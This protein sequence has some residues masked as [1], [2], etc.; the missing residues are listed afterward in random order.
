MNGPKLPK[1]VRE[2]GEAADAALKALQDGNE[3]ET[4]SKPKGENT[5]LDENG[6]PIQAAP[7][8][9]GTPP[10]K[11]D[12]KSKDGMDWKTEHGKL[13]QKYNVLK[14]KYDSEVPALHGEVREVKESLR[15]L[16][17]RLDQGETAPPADPGE[18][19]KTAFEV[20]AETVELF[21]ENLIKFI[22]QRAK[23]YSDS[24]VKPLGERMDT[25]THDAESDRRENFFTKLE[26]AHSDWEQINE[27]EQFKKF[28]A[29]IVPELGVERQVIINNAINSG[30][31]EP[32]ILQITAFK[33]RFS[34]QGEQ[35]N[36][37]HQETPSGE[38]T[39][40][41]DPGT[42]TDVE[43]IK[44][45]DIQAFYKDAA[46]GKYRGRDEEFIRLER[47]IQKASE[48]GKIVMDLSGGKQPVFTNQ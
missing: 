14:G 43:S 42:N 13:L 9:P 16:Q 20:P 6:N 34:N 26:E 32:V 8:D 4:G 30:N 24:A 37:S 39:P 46:N 33:K 3:G 2:A 29:E 22:D 1:K 36:L 38:G 41:A 25:V 17:T 23:L 18:G 19:G 40:P 10:A 28:L 45:S 27:T 47:M 11:K 48:A 35:S 31:P 15:T 12:D 21:G 44:E 5:G 7:V